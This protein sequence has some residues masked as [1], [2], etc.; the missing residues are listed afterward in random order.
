MD[1]VLQFRIELLGV[2]PPVWRRIQV[3]AEY[4]LWD[5]HVAIQDSMG[6]EDC[7]LH[8]FQVVG[9]DGTYGIPDP[10]GFEEVIPGHETVADTVFSAGSPVGTYEYDF[11]DSWIHLLVLESYEPVE[12]G[13]RYPRCTGGARRCPPEDCGGPHMYSEALRARTDPLHPD[14]EMFESWLA[15]DFDPEDF[16]VDGILFTDPKERWAQ[17]S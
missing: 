6:W 5:L 1:H 14:R 10:D 4:T 2:D 12:S 17:S 11:G 8:A 9:S 7:H 16:D 13:V 15:P 3:P